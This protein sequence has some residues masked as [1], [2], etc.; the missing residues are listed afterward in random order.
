[1]KNWVRLL[2]AKDAVHLAPEQKELIK[3]IADGGWGDLNLG[4]TMM[5]NGKPGSRGYE[6]VSWLNQYMMKH[7]IKDTHALVM[8]LRQKYQLF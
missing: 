3:Q 6:Y 8:R 1:M 4:D 2:T 7:K 5:Y